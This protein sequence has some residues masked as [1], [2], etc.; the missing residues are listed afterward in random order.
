MENSLSSRYYSCLERIKLACKKAR[1]DPKAVHLLAV[2]KGQSA[3]VIRRLYQLGQRDFG[4]N[5]VV[6]MQKKREE[7][8]DL[9]DI[10]WHF[11]GAIQS[12][13]IKH[14][15]SCY[16]IHGLSSLRHAQLLAAQASKGKLRV[17]LQVNLSR[18]PQRQGFL[19]SDMITSALSLKS[20]DNLQIVGLMA[21]LPLEGDKKAWFS[22]MQNCLSRL[23]QDIPTMTELSMGMSEDFEEAIAYGATFVRLGTIL[24]GSRS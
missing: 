11:I 12:T 19:P 23:A 16:A 21:I 10:R 15:M 6:E 18:E 3:D 5:Y 14:L 2:T 1:R 24:C 17:F 4:E 22:W 8:K 20:L 7:L 9:V 13:H